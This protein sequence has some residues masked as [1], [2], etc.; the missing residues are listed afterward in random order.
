MIEVIV[1]QENKSQVHQILEGVVV[2]VGDYVVPQVDAFQLNH[3][4]KCVRGQVTYA[5]RTLCGF[6]TLYL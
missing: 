6:D 1:F 4:L 5:V 3:S 2:N